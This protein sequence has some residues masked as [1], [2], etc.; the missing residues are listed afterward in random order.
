MKNRAVLLIS[1]WAPRLGITTTGRLGDKLGNA[2]PTLK[3][4]KTTNN[5]K[6]H[7]NPCVVLPP[8]LL[9]HRVLQSSLRVEPNIIWFGLLFILECF[10]HLFFP[11]A[12][13]THGYV[14]PFFQPLVTGQPIPDQL[15]PSGR[16]KVTTLEH[17]R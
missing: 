7:I 6:H 10:E 3:G 2:F 5:Q 4:A 15:C 17:V 14:C 1:N 13:R 12:R 11:S 16:T 8:I 9:A